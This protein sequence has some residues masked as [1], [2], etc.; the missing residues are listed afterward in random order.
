MATPTWKGPTD[1]LVEANNSPMFSNTK[2]GT[3]KTRI[4]HGLHSFCES[5]QWDFAAGT[6]GS[7]VESGYI[8]AGVS[9]NKLRG[10]IGQLSVTWEASGA[11]SGAILPPDEVAVSPNNENPRIERHPLFKPLEDLAVD[12]QWVLEIAENQARAQSP[13]ERRRFEDMITGSS[14][15]S[16][17]KARYHKLLKKLRRGMESYYLASVTY[18]WTTYSWTIPSETTHG[19]YAE[20]PGG[21]LEGYFVA[22][23]QWLRAADD[24]QMQQGMWRHTRMWIGG[25]D[26]TWD[27]DVYGTP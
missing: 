3:T 17:Q 7:G 24:L 11:G 1:Q 26:G 12:D 20:N 13:T 6:V 5:V 22:G 4:F 2:N 14:L 25:P 27:S 9:V 23:M 16:D 10:N 18:F 15:T 21:L 19:G 8:S